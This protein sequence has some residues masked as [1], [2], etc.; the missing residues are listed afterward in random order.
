MYTGAI[1]PREFRGVL[2][3]V[4]PDIVHL[5]GSWDWH[6]AL[7]RQM[8]AAADCPV[9]LSPH[10]GLSPS[11]MAQDFWKRKLPQIAAY[12]LRLVR[13]SFVLHAATQQELSDIKALGWKRR[14]ALITAGTG[15]NNR[16]RMAGEFRQLYQKVIDTWIR[17][18]LSDIERQALWTMLAAYCR[19][20]TD[21]AD[22]KDTA[23]TAQSTKSV[24]LLT[25]HDWQTL[26]VYATDHGIRDIMMRGAERLGAKPREETHELPSRFS[27]KPTLR[28]SPAPTAEHKTSGDT[29]EARL[30]TD[31]LRLRRM[32][33]THETTGH[34]TAPIALA[35]D[36]FR[37]I[38][39]GD[40]EEDALLYIIDQAG[41]RAFAARLMAILANTLSLPVG[42][43]PLDPLNDRKT[44][45]LM[46]ELMRI[47]PL[48][49]P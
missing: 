39:Y 14:V 15:E 19:P 17:G 5:H 46:Q 26:Q 47:E 8:A 42:F 45:I 29:P 44:S 21:E 41:L 34:D 20:A 23:H 6:L 25:A 22:V 37:R 12:Q 48:T 32:L 35:T 18:R 3:D 11:A 43:M 1:M 9:V 31:I 16:E 28:L 7:A 24:E 2:R 30:A 4:Q 33:T 13:K 38:R 27:A 49:T 10:G 40:Y 36:I